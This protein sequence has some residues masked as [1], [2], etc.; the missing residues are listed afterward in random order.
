MQMMNSPVKLHDVLAQSPRAAQLSP[1]GHI[2]PPEDH[3]FLRRDGVRP[4]LIE[5]QPIIEAGRF[6][7]RPIR[8]S[9]AGL[10]AL[11]TSDRRLAEGTR[12]IPHPLPPGAA[13]A[14]VQRSTQDKRDE[15]VWVLDGSAHGQ[16]EVLGIV[17]LQRM[18][19]DQSEITFWVAPG[20][21][22]TGFA[23]EA[24]NAI[25][26]ANPHAS[27]TL[28]AEVFQDNPG[29]ARVLVNAGFD[30]LGDAEAWSVARNAK[31]PTWTYVRRMA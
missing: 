7:L 2:S 11:Y 18:D 4:E 26:A 31:V 13:E 10:I 25:V 29:S 28:F 24:V 5:L 21:W 12:A 6:N 27:R 8:N 22:N 17:G 15:D 14:Y 1:E 3:L 30:Y 9:D 16:A 19:R 23:S 20:L